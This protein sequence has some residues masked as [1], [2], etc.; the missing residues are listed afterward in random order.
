MTRKTK[1]V[2]SA[3][4]L[5]FT[6]TDTPQQF[7]DSWRNTDRT[8]RWTGDC[9]Q[10][11][12]RT[13]QFDDGENDPRGPLGDHAGDP[14]HLADHLAP[15]EAAEVERVGGVTLPACFCCTNDYDRYQSLTREAVRQAR[16]LGA[17][18]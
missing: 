18:L 12:R 13:Y 2:K 3:E 5:N 7:H 10:C 6:L 1:I 14:F 4:F 16:K 15:D 11:G 9:D 17:D 8:M